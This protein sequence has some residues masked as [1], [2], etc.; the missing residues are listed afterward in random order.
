MN[1]VIFEWRP[2][3]YILV[4]KIPVAIDTSNTED[5]IRWGTG[6]KKTENRAVGKDMIH[7]LEVSTVFLGLDHAISGPPLLFETMVFAH[8]D[9]PKIIEGELPG[10]GKYRFEFDRESLEDVEG[11]MNRYSTWAEAEVGHK[12]VV[13]MVRRSF[14][15]VI[16]KKI[17]K[18]R[19]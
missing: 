9:T 15:Q 7:H 5:F 18:I 3:C 1:D 6:L 16:D 14:L 13:A 11:Y 8:L 2:H 12:N 4:E 17:R 19:T 10:G